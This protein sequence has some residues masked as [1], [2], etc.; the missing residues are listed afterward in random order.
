MQDRRQNA[1]D[2]VIY[3]GVA[4]VGG[5]GATRDCIVRNISEN[6]AR[7]EFK[8]DIN[9]PKEKMSLTQD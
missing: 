8:N 2:K 6:G 9:L 3:G 7:I 5:R 4:D 1:R